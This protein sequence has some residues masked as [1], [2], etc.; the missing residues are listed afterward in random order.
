MLA[1][2]INAELFWHLPR[3]PLSFLKIFLRSL[4]IAHG[5]PQVCA[6]EKSAGKIGPQANGFAVIVER[7]IQL[8]QRA[9]SYAAA[10]ISQS[11]IAFQP[12]RLVVVFQRAL[13]VVQRA[14]VSARLKK[15][16]GSGGFFNRMA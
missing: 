8:V 14:A 2:R 15:I 16:S 6:V 10:V 3:Q 12:D 1:H 13:D 11:K 4:L 9:M 7:G 5:F